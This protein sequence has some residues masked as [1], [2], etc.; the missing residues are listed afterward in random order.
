VLRAR[1]A[2]EFKRLDLPDVPGQVFAPT[3]Y[4]TTLAITPALES[5]CRGRAVTFVNAGSTG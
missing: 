3:E 2:N 5:F 1:H 4:H